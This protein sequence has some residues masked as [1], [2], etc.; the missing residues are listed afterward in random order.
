MFS[1]T[2]EFGLPETYNERPT[3]AFLKAVDKVDA[4]F[5]EHQIQKLTKK[6]TTCKPIPSMSGIEEQFGISYRVKARTMV[7]LSTLHLPLSEINQRTGYLNAKLLPNHEPI[8][9][10]VGVLSPIVREISGQTT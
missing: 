2:K 6:A 7:F 3:Y 1:E 10:W 4:V 8:P 5:S 9:C